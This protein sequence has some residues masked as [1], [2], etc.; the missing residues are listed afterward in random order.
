MHVSAHCIS[1]P[2]YEPEIAK[3]STWKLATR[4]EKELS[5]KNTIHLKV[6]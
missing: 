3:F 5:N 1:I 6:K 2:G 4:A